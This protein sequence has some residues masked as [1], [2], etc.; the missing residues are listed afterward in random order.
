M[1]MT[2]RP[3]T[4][5]EQAYCYTQSHQIWSHAG[6][7]GHLRTD[8]GSSGTEFFS[9][10]FDFRNNLKSDDFKAEFYAYGTTIS[11]IMREEQAPPLR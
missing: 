8:F 10:F 6:L 1:E 5:A 7:I 11:L 4:Q 2:L 9:T 3:M